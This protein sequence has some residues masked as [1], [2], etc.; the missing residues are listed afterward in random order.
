MSIYE[1]CLL[2][3]CGLNALISL[4]FTFIKLF[5]Y[6][7]KVKNFKEITKT[8]K[9]YKKYLDLEKKFGGKTNA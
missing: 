3:I 2:S 7:K 6:F 5:A 8:D 9:E 4:I 1:I